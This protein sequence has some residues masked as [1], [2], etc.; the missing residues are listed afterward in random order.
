MATPSSFTSTKNDGGSLE[1]KNPPSKASQPKLAKKKPSPE[2]IAAIRQARAEKKKLEEDRR[3]E[4]EEKARVEAEAGSGPG[5]DHLDAKGNQLYQPR[6]WARLSRDV[7]ARV[8]GVPVGA[9]EGDRIKVISWNML[10]QGLVRRKLFPGSDCLKFKERHPGLSSELVGH[11]WDLGLFQEVDKI[12]F[13]SE[14]LRENGYEWCFMKGYESKQHG[15]MIS[16]RV[17]KVKRRGFRGRCFEKVPLKKKM[18]YLDDESVSGPDQPKRSACSRVTRNVALFVALKLAANPESFDS[19]SPPPRPKGVIAATT[20]LFWHPMH[21]YERCRQSGIL[22]RS[23]EE[24]RKSM[25]P[26][27]KDWPVVLAGDFNDQPHSATYH[28]LTGKRLT[29][30]CKEEIASSSVVHK[31]IDEKRLR[32]AESGKQSSPNGSGEATLGSPSD[33]KEADRND[34]MEDVDEEEEEGEEDEE[35]E[36]EGGKDDQMLKNCRP[37]TVDDQLLTLSEMIQL[38]DLSR[39]PPDQASVIPSEEGSDSLVEE[40]ERI[41]LQ[42]AYGARYGDVKD[43]EESQ[44]FFGSKS[45][46]RERYD[47]P[48]WNPETPNVHTG[49]SKEPMWTIFSSL[50]SLTLDYIFLLPQAVGPSTNSKEAAP[51]SKNGGA[52]ITYPEITSLLRTHG[53][54]VLRPGIPR[55]GVCASDHIAIA[56]EIVI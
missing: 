10:A 39:P 43:P 49:D 34:S 53:T 30:H 26:E 20:H 16:W 40:E 8:N 32:L 23:L 17:D 9:E 28:L 52:A 5:L 25:G 33:N 21:A 54:E 13:H 15:L 41:G 29:D 38:H 47:D 22:V 7:P 11:G 4:K 3:L 55:K 35:E 31:S 48:D 42:S 19:A 6:L 12:E 56:A 24:F 50:F 2:E 18:I 1:T 44:N 27:Y 37:A 45:R 51:A 36:E 14:T 46:G